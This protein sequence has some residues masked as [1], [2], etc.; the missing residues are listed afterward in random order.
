M[1]VG[2]ILDFLRTVFKVLIHG[3]MSR[4]AVGRFLFRFQADSP[5]KHMLQ[6]YLKNKNI[7]LNMLSYLDIQDVSYAGCA[8]DIMTTLFTSRAPS[9]RTSQHSCIHAVRLPPR[10][11]FMSVCLS[12]PLP[13]KT[14]QIQHLESTSLCY[15]SG[16]A[17]QIP[18]NSFRNKLKEG[19]LIS[20]ARTNPTSTTKYHF[21]LFSY[22]SSK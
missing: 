15:V 6:K 16:E 9:Q 4:I 5:G 18:S 7:T 17:E 14:F 8:S 11:M 20:L 13:P 10:K 12:Q 21:M 1:S 3:Y 19:T 2:N 22:L